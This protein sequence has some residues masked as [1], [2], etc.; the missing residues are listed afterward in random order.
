[1]ADRRLTSLQT[2]ELTL[3]YKQLGNAIEDGDIKFAG[4]AHAQLKSFL[5]EEGYRRQHREVDLDLDHQTTE[6]KR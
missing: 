2:T 4:L 1:M 5:H 6:E 3:I